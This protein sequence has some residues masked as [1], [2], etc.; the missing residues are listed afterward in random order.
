MLEVTKEQAETKFAD[1][2]DT[3]TM[4]VREFRDLLLD[5]TFR[6]MKAK[7]EKSEGFDPQRHGHLHRIQVAADNFLNAL[8]GQY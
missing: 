1:D 2:I 6:M 7:I 3:V 8:S 5:E 4:V